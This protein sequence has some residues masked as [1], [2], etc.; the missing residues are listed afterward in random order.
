VS[1]AE[2][3]FEEALAR[4]GSLVELP[5]PAFP[6]CL[7]KSEAME[8]LLAALEKASAGCNNEV[9]GAL[10]RADEASDN[11]ARRA[12]VYKT[13]GLL[14]YLR[15]DWEGAAKAYADALACAESAADEAAELESLAGLGNSELKC[16][17]TERAEELF[18][19]GLERADTSGRR[20]L[21]GTF[22]AG[23]G[24]VHRARG[25]ADG[26][27]GRFSEAREAFKETGDV[28][29]EVEMLVEQGDDYRT[30][31]D[32]EQAAERLD[33]ALEL[34]ADRPVATVKALVGMGRIHIRT[35][36]YEAAK[37]LFRRALSI[38]EEIDDQRLVSNVYNNLGNVH[39]YQCDYSS[40]I[41]AYEK[42]LAINR[43]LGN[44][45]VTSHII[46]NLGSVFFRKGDYPAALSAY[47]QALELER[48]HGNTTTAA[49][50]LG[51]VGIIRRVRCEFDE[52]IAAYREA[53]R[54]YVE[55]VDVFGQSVT[56][57]NLSSVFLETGVYDEAGEL[58][59]KTLELSRRSGVPVTEAHCL[60]NLGMLE[61]YRG[62]LDRAEKHLGEAHRIHAGIK[63]HFLEAWALNSLGRVAQERG[64][65]PAAL[66]HFT[67]A[68]DLHRRLD[69]REGQ[70]E[71]MSNRGLI[72]AR[73]GRWGGALADL[74]GAAHIAEGIQNPVQEAR[75]ECRLGEA[76][77][78][79]GDYAAAHPLL[80]RSYGVFQR[81]GVPLEQ[82]EALGLLGRLA[83]GLGHGELACAYLRAAVEGYASL[84]ALPGRIARLNGLL[85][86]C[87]AGLDLG[88]IP[89][90]DLDSPPEIPLPPK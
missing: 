9:V 30:K 79:D 25:D 55:R 75:V 67:R 53:L 27:I 76:L 20:N 28:T 11:D 87:G 41:Q 19:R 47:E 65:D 18:L 85:A 54:I 57:A 32:Y 63:N 14:G 45:A 44:Q 80:T 84:G 43:R 10:R 4:L 26:A 6:A 48:R 49:Q 81:Y 88:K 64:D 21:A 15:G 22:L 59:E 51:N 46:H 24:R 37:Q 35:C 34:S 56:M 13:A 82:A 71:S 86:E 52:S 68:L 61:F 70:A 62:D 73:L 69:H 72:L 23:L 90:L 33:G 8:H 5:R 42:A 74:K 78:T 89:E 3:R 38:A 29:R 60:G 7:G 2:R 16:F 36:D 66:E 12:H 39:F 40:S 83:R 1:D 77:A 58:L 31:G 50:C 17:N